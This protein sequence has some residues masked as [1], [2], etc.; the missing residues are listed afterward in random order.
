MYKPYSPHVLRC[1]QT[2]E[3]GIEPPLSVTQVLGSCELAVGCIFV[4]GFKN[5]FFNPKESDISLV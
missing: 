2:S 3:E 4:N 1:P 5:K